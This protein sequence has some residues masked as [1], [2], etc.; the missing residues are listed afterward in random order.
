[1]RVQPDKLVSHKWGWAGR[2]VGSY[3][4]GSLCLALWTFTEKPQKNPC[5]KCSVSPVFAQQDQRKLRIKGSAFEYITFISELTL[6][7]NPTA[8]LWDSFRKQENIL[9]ISTFRMPT[10]RGIN[11]SWLCAAMFPLA[12]IYN[13][14]FAEEPPE[15][16]G[17]LR[18][19]YHI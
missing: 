4:R 12:H 17:I 9:L 7:C 1:M 8:G 15:S 5:N 19:N 18:G 6:I 11:C 16:G 14:V 2:Q 3:T 10:F 13:G